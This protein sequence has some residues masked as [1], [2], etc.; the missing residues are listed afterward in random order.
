MLFSSEGKSSD[1][2]LQE[3]QLITLIIQIDKISEHVST[4]IHQ[5]VYVYIHA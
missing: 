1:A 2:V 4:H 5:G 3:P